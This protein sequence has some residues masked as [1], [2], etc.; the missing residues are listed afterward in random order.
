MAV[1]R[2]YK[3]PVIINSSRGE[4]LWGDACRGQEKE[5]KFQKPSPS[6]GKLCSTSQET[7]KPQICRVSETITSLIKFLI[8][9]P[10]NQSILR[11]Y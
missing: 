1:H 3:S 6:L 10:K 5:S 9:A 11:E 8:P 7:P 2:N 4:G